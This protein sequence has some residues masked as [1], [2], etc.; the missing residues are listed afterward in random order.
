MLAVSATMLI[1]VVGIIILFGSG[2]VNIA[3]DASLIF[4]VY[5]LGGLLVAFACFGLLTSSG[6]IG[7][8]PLGVNVRLGGSVVAAVLVAGGGSLY[9]LY[10]RPS[11]FATRI[12]FYEVGPA[13][14]VPV[15]GTFRVFMGAAVQDIPIQSD[16]SILIQNLRGRT[17]VRFA[18]DAPEYEVD[19]SQPAELV[20]VPDGLVSIKVRRKSPFEPFSSARIRTE[21]D[22][23]IVNRMASSG[24]S[25]TLRLILWSDS[26]RPVPLRPGARVILTRA[27]LPFRQLDANVNDGTMSSIILVRPRSAH[28][29]FVDILMGDDYL[30]ILEMGLDLQV[31]L[32]FADPERVDGGTFRTELIRF[33]A[34]EFAIQ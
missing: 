13:S 1:V 11:A 23:A 31:E 29:V 22:A 17:R 7:G 27:S 21:F 26:E 15:R 30:T 33:S 14:P 4:L 32:K 5:I 18:L 2:V 3:I 25:V 8:K 34:P 19:P 16:G 9:E 24:V 28:T 10:V 6:E 20:P 12:I